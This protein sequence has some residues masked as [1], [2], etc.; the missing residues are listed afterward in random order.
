MARRKTKGERMKIRLSTIAILTLAAGTGFILFQTSQ[1]VQRSEDRLRDMRQSLARENESVR[2]LEAEWDYLNRPD[3]LE[4]LTRQYL[5]IQ[6]PVPES[7]VSDS[8]QVPEPEAPALPRR[9]P[10][11]VAQPA[12]MKMQESDPAA[13]NPPMPPPA[14]AAGNDSRQQ[15]Q[16]L[17]NSL[18][19]Q[20]PA[21]GGRQ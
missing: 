18:T 10:V 7:L 17:L 4:E 9:K 1:N 6:S 3:R 16:D 14:S 12:V 15:F 13:A 20:E 19:D 2:V 11:F 5:K 8:R 21:A